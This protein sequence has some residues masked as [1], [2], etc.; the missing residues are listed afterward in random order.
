MFK[1][2]LNLVFR[3]KLRTFLTSLGIMIAVM[4]MTFILFGM[5]DLKTM[6]LGQFTEQFKPTDLYV[7]NQDISFSGIQS[8]PS[9]DTQ[10][11]EFVVVNDDVVSK[12]K[13]VDGVTGVYPVLLITG[14]EAYLEGDNTPYP[15]FSI[16]SMDMPGDSAMYKSL[17][18]NDLQLDNGEMYVSDFV[19]SFFQISNPE[20]I[21]GK[22]L[23]LKSVPSGLLSVANK[24]ML[25]R[26]YTFK[27]VGVV[28]TVNKAFW[29]NNDDA[30]GMLVD[31]GGFANKQEYISKIGYSQLFVT[32]QDG[33]TSTVEDY[34]VKDMGLSVMSTKTMIDFMSTITN[35]L[36]IALIV[37]GGISALVAS[38]GIINTMIMSIYEQTKEIGIIK[39]IGASDFQVLIIFLLQSALIGFIGGVMGLTISYLIMMAADP[40]VVNLLS[41]QGFS[42]VTQFFHFQPLNAIY[43]T[44]ASILVG[45][46]A[47][48]Y[49][50]M[51]AA[52]LDPVNALRYE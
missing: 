47:G 2:A 51:K 34:I 23:V 21:I 36:T 24:N 5:S 4:L 12:I 15:T 14:V 37:F 22:N 49:P 18:G 7:S 11:K 10:K 30:L 20:D 42:T 48:I 50:S 35:G 39:A 43:L 40:I 41:Q 33:K 28:D 8:A 26:E 1:Y 46:L 45:I 6:I 3:R 52:K 31:M 13:N 27:I 29:I 44:L 17:I 16:N 9:K 19:T 32:T 38:I 25:N